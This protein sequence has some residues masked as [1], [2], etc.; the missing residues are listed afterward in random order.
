MLDVMFYEAFKEEEVL[1]K[2][3]LNPK[4]KAKF[5]PQ[6]IQEVSSKACLATV[7]S[8]RT[9][10]VISL[11]WAKNLS[12]ILTRSSGYDHLE[13]FRKQASS[14]IHYGYLPHY[15]SRAVAEQAILMILALLRRLPAQIQQMD[16][17][18][19]DGLTG[20][21]A[22]GS[23][24]LVVGVGRI[25]LEVVKIAQ[26]L[27]MDVRA[28]DLIQKQ[29]KLKYVSLQE[30]VKWARA[31]VCALPLTSSTEKILN[32]R[33]LSQSGQQRILVNVS[34]GEIT[35]L[36]DLRRLLKEGQLCGLGLD[37]YEHEDRLAEFVRNKGKQKNRPLALTPEFKILEELKTYDNVIFT[38]HNA[39]N[40]FE[41]LNSKAQQSVRAV[42]MFL[43]NGRF[44]DEIPAK[45]RM[46]C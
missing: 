19:R 29:K 31:V 17:F 6:T 26:A 5:F 28:V 39:F 18:L 10:S 16:Q 27:K 45:R 11:A 14:K 1:L 36:A 8:T 7:I 35:P 33:L 2:K 13:R 44:P 25:G 24:I 34:R 40:T 30:G 43:K 41:A 3:Y 32:Y 23:K 38:P 4:V 46:S 20:H 42:E 22:E 37:V 15:C 12:G 21:E 9:Q